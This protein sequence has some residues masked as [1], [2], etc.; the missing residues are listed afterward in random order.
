MSGPTHFEVN[1]F[2]IFLR[3]GAGTVKS[4]QGG[5]MNLRN[6]VMGASL[7]FGMMGIHSSFAL[8]IPAAPTDVAVSYMSLSECTPS[9]QILF[10]VLG[11]ND[12]YKK[13]YAGCARV[14]WKN[15]SAPTPGIKVFIDGVQIMTGMLGSDDGLNLPESYVLPVP[16]FPA[17]IT[18][19]SCMVNEYGMYRTENCSSSDTITV[20]KARRR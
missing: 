18:V 16:S 13:W 7:V 11:R 19:Y 12:S 15:N 6:V 1:S 8:D 3:L 5:I 10:P 9:L 14:T 20:E 4:N 2:S 17:N